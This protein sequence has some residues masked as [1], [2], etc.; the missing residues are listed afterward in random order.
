MTGTP[1]Q[2]DVVGLVEAFRAGE[3][4]PAE[5]LEATLASVEASDLNAV[6]HVDPDAARRAA[7]SADVSLPYGGVPLAVKELLAVGGWPAAEGSIPLKDE[8]FTH[9]DISVERLKGAGAVAA[10]QTTS[11]EFG[12]TN[13]TTTKLHGATRNPWNLERTPGGSSGGSA[14]G[15]A[16]GLFTLAT[17]SDGGGSIRIPAGFCGLIGL[18]STFGR[19][20]RGPGAIL[21]NATSVEG[22][23]SRSV[24][25]AARYLDVTNGFDGRDPRSLPR[26]EGY[27]AGL[28]THA[29]EVSSLRVAIV[30]DLSCA[31]VGPETEELV[32][33]A[34]EELVAA[35]GMQR[36]DLD[37]RLP[38]IMG[39]WG[40]TGGV[41]I[42]K[43]LGERWP[44]CA[45]DL[46]GVERYGQFAADKGFTIDAMARAETRRAEFNNVMAA[47]FDEVDIVLAATNPS[48]AFAAE[49]RIPHVF[50]GRESKAGNN[51]ALTAPANIF[52]NPAIALP[53]GLA[54]DGLPVSLQV[55]GP[56]FREDLLLE[57]ARIWERVHPVELAI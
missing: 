37:L 5:E 22:T 17:A 25:D 27:E 10:V 38:S 50:E 34:A 43:S 15:V 30:P 29:G 21:G 16:G 4:S 46:G 45:P 56:H 13:Q 31:V 11:S 48:T 33:A 2:G 1:W 19:I 18:K 53:A 51:G 49:G 55:L 39:V 42:R 32:I 40:A 20:P 3:R 54:S 26:V 6:C 36:V 8:I 9:D 7:A 14:A 52:G 23:V 28:G 47:M 12:A 35:T 57:I 41:G 24:R 44:D